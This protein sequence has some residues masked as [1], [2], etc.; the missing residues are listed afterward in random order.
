MDLKRAKTELRKL[1]QEV[2]SENSNKYYDKFGEV[3]ESY[4]VAGGRGR[5][6]YDYLMELDEEFGNK[7]KLKDEHLVDIMNRIVGYAPPF[8]KIIFDDLNEQ[9]GEW[10]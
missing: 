3:V 2:N 9:T 4:R 10:R 6:I 1:I 7:D 8:R 5:Y